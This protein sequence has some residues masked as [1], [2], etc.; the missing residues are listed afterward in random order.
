MKMS[1]GV[2]GLGGGSAHRRRGRKK[3]RKAAAVV[4]VATVF[5][6]V[7]SIASSSPF[8]GPPIGA[9]KKVCLESGGVWTPYLQTCKV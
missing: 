5:L 6:C 8:Y 9:A 2:P 3:M 7:P 1:P 4:A